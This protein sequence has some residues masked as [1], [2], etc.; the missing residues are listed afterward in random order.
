MHVGLFVTCL[1]DT[2]YPRVGLAV[3][4]VLRH[5]GCTVD[6]PR[7][8]TCCGQPGFNSGFDHEAAGLVRRMAGV[9]EA[10][11]RVVTPS[12]SCAAMVR[13]HGPELL[14]GDREGRAAAQRLAAKTWEFHTFLRDE[15]RVDIAAHLR[16][17]EPTT[18]HYPCHA[19]GIYSVEDLECWLGAG[20]EVRVPR[21]SVPVSLAGASGS[22]KPAAVV[23]PARADLCCGF[24]GVFS[25]E[26]PEVS[27]AMARDKV[28]ELAATG[29]RRVVCN[30]AA[31][32]LQ[33]SGAARRQGIELRLVHLAEL[34]AESLGLLE[35]EP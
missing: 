29:A 32:A 19:R 17:G 23:A 13:Q 18:F 16:L 30:E 14:A 33:I 3:A 28:A 21:T 27:G 25:V 8:Q 24:G 6:F 12:A 15:L 22:E 1:T 35:P 2:F 7:G 26:Y 4:R 31:C 5:F 9:F 11:E 20:R 34:L 10:Y